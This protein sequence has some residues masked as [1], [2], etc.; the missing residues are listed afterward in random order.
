MSYD[1]ENRRREEQR[2]DERRREDQRLELQRLEDQRRR[3]EQSRETARREQ[4]RRE[5]Q[6]REDQR[7]QD[8]QRRQDD[9]RAEERRRQDD[10]QAQAKRQERTAHYDRVDDR[11]REYHNA[12]AARD[13]QIQQDNRARLER[14]VAEE[15]KR[16]REAAARDDVNAQS[17][18]YVQRV[19]AIPELGR[20]S[21]GAGAVQV[22]AGVL[23]GTMATANEVGAERAAR[24]KANGYQSVVTRGD[25]ARSGS[26]AFRTVFGIFAVLLV[27]LGLTGYLG[28]FSSRASRLSESNP[29]KTLPDKDM[30]QQ[31]VRAIL[32]GTDRRAKSQYRLAGSLAMGKNGLQLDTCLAAYF[33]NKAYSNPSAS[34][35]F[36]PAM[37]EAVRSLHEM[38]QGT[39]AQC[40]V[41]IRKNN[42]RAPLHQLVDVQS[43]LWHNQNV[44]SGLKG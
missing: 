31:E 22:L 35:E 12:L 44:F 7:R 11:R 10:A 20:Q 29:L 4:Q 2:R 37:L 17:A 39:L 16:R 33:A 18:T 8:E 41:T 6:R 23:Q 3:D 13:A 30:T 1:D 25:A 40:K 28:G 5:D 19:P 14:D 27:A 9:A 26:G 36:E 34:A 32:L 42:P 21:P 43:K 38:T 15:R 24:R